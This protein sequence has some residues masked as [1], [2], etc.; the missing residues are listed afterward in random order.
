MRKFIHEK[1]EIFRS[2]IKDYPQ[3][4]EFGDDLYYDEILISLLDDEKRGGA[5]IIL[6]HAQKFAESNPQARKHLENLEIVFS[7]LFP[8][9]L[10]DEDW[11]LE[12]SLLR[13]TPECDF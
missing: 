8:E 3:A 1:D 7:E 6:R 12:E 10:S 4:P 2:L 11:D 13:D 5:E 9:D